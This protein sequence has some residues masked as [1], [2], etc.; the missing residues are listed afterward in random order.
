MPKNRHTKNKHAKNK[1]QKG[2]STGT[3]SSDLFGNIEALMESGINLIVDSVELIV[4]VVELPGDVGAAYEEP[5]AQLLK[6]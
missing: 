2:G 1:K 3:S 4:E 5:A 6:S